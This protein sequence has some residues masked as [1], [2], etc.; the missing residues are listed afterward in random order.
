ME[1]CYYA[2]GNGYIELRT[3]PA[4]LSLYFEKAS[5]FAPELKDVTGYGAE[6]IE[7]IVGNICIDYVEKRSPEHWVIHIGGIAPYD[8]EDFRGFLNA[9]LPAVASGEIIFLGQDDILWRWKTE[10]PGKWTKREGIY[11]FLDRIP[12]ITKP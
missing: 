4:N 2:F 11:H 8:D 9:L 5:E 1:Y 3:F 6:H 12:E 7:G 10:E